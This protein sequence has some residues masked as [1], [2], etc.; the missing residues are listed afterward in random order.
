MQREMNSSN[1]CMETPACG[2]QKFLGLELFPNCSLHFSCALAAALSLFQH[3]PFFLLN[4]SFAV[5][6]FLWERKTFSLST[7]SAAPT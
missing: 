5:G 3:K 6:F 2:K 4:K 1:M 7:S